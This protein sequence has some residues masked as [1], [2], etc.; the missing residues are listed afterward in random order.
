MLCMLTAHYLL[1]ATLSPAPLD[2]CQSPKNLLHH[3]QNSS[4]KEAAPLLLKL[5]PISHPFQQ[6]TGT[7]L[8]NIFLTFRPC[9]PSSNTKDYQDDR[10]KL[11]TEVHMKTSS[12]DHKLKQKTSQHGI[13]K[14]IFPMRT[15][16]DW[17][18]R[19]TAQSSSLEVFPRPN[20]TKP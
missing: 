11:L 13:R 17:L 8:F 18:P 19:E 20:F 9:L 6:I 3:I 14:K 10:A 1:I 16:K 15:V 12:S 5:S 7:E 4:G 2:D